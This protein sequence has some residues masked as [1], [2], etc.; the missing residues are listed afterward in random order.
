MMK[1]ALLLAMAFFAAGAAC[2]RPPAPPPEQREEARKAPRH[3]RDPGRALEDFLAWLPEED[4]AALRKQLAENPGEEQRIFRRYFEAKREKEIEKIRKLRE[5]YFQANGDEARRKAKEKLAE[6]IAEDM[7]RH[8]RNAERR[9]QG[10]E[11]QLADFQKRVTEAKARL[12]TMKQGKD[13]K[14]RKMLED[15]TDPAKKFPPV[16]PAEGK[17]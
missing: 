6:Q 17:K 16:S 1:K 8:L 3:F 4:R 10:M 7:E 2:A 12:E 5:A 13:E 15:I 9:I 11:T 14:L